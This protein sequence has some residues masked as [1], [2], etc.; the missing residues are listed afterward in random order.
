MSFI[1]NIDKISILEL[2]NKW[3]ETVNKTDG[4]ICL[5]SADAKYRLLNNGI[6]FHNLSHNELSECCIG[7]SQVIL[8]RGFNTIIDQDHYALWCW[9]G[10]VISFEMYDPDNSY[11]YFTRDEHEIK[12][13]FQAVIRTSLAG[14]RK[15]PQDK[16]EW[17]KQNEIRDL[18]DLN[19]K[20]MIGKSGLILS[21]LVFPLLEATL[22][23]NCREYIE[24]DGKIKKNFII[25]KKQGKN[26]TYS[27]GE[28]CS[29]LRD[30]LFLYYNEVASIACRIKLDLFRNHLKYLDKSIDP[31]DL[32]YG[33]RNSSLHGS[34]S[35]QTI[36]GTLLN[37]VLLLILEEME[38]KFEI[39]KPKVMEKVLWEKST[40]SNSRSPWS[41]Y[42]PY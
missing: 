36:G 18:M 28:T 26:R 40:N 23:K 41:F 32:I 1:E 35:Y 25:K 33:W 2:C 17:Q 42:P 21:Y 24:Y 14:I 6:Q 4:S 7:L 5:G 37:L 13:L 31:F 38:G 8:L 27:I 10:E 15:P 19:S 22:K 9:L 3:L 29:N 11:S 30:L 12:E 39:I 34:N 16:D 20:E